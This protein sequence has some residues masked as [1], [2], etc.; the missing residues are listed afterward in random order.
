MKNKDTKILIVVGGRSFGMTCAIKLAEISGKPLEQII[1]EQ[2]AM[3]I[4]TPPLLP[5][6]YIVQT[7]PTEKQ[8]KEFHKQEIRKGWKR[9]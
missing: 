4:T 6:S 1:K 3:K 2:R 7:T 9:K 5:E 8:Q